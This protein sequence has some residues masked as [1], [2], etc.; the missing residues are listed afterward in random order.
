MHEI[1]PQLTSRRTIMISASSLWKMQ[2][3]GAAASLSC[4]PNEETRICCKGKPGLM[5]APTC[6][7]ASRPSPSR[8]LHGGCGACASSLVTASRRDVAADSH[9]RHRHGL[10]TRPP[11]DGVARREI[12]TGRPG[13][14][15][16]PYTSFSA[17]AGWIYPAD[18]GISQPVLMTRQEW[19]PWDSV[20]PKWTTLVLKFP[21][22]WLKLFDAHERC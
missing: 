21:S 15:R 3:G 10:N 18:P 1:T 9:G 13:C 22:T 11:R 6:P 17:N 8:S 19:S 20:R 2:A 5:Q 12:P 16:S 14:C 4:F 7:S